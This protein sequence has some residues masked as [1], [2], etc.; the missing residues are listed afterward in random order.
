MYLL[1]PVKERRKAESRLDTEWPRPAQAGRGRGHLGGSTSTTA[2][3][4]PS[5][6]AALKARLPVGVDTRC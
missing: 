2:Q 1:L 5:L 3:A 4:G 6:R